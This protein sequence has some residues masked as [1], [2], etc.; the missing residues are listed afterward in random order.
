M[1]NVT[2]TQDKNFN[3]KGKVYGMW[4]KA[5]DNRALRSTGWR[6]LRDV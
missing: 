4:K 3:R 1:K 5:N 2:N 6:D